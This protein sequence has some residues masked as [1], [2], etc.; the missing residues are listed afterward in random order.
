MIAPSKPSQR[1]W[2][3]NILIFGASGTGKTRTWLDLQRLTGARA[4]C[5]D[6]H[7]G[8][9]AWAHTYPDGWDV[10]HSSSPEE[11][12][13]RATDADGR[14]DPALAAAGTEEAGLGRPGPV[15]V[16]GEG[17]AL[18]RAEADLVEAGNDNPLDV[19]TPEREV[20]GLLCPSELRGGPEP[21]RLVRERLPQRERLL[22]PERGQP[23]ARR[24]RVDAV[25]RVRACVRVTHEDQP[26][27]NSTLR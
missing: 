25:V 22:D 14:L 18:V 4:I 13:E 24:D 2:R 12:D 26:S 11:L 15:A 21:D 17:A 7:H 10:V 23:V 20:E 3:P 19:A 1:Q 5:F 16:G 6:T 27:Q 8:T 9:D